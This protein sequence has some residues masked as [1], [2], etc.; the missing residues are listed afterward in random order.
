MVYYWENSG[1]KSLF[2]VFRADVVCVRCFQPSAGKSQDED[3]VGGWA[4]MT[5]SEIPFPGTIPK[6]HWTGQQEQAAGGVR[7]QRSV[8]RPGAVCTDSES[9]VPWG[10]QRWAFTSLNQ[11][12]RELGRCFTSSPSK[13]GSG[14]CL[15]P[16]QKKRQISNGISRP[17]CAVS[18]WWWVSFPLTVHLVS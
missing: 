14:M 2:F 11:H 13:V 17:K 12:Q 15:S 4:K 9:S 16:R 5:L 3:L 1:K 10:R 7:R 6:G 8:N 18:D